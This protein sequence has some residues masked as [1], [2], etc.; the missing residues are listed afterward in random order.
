[1][2]MKLPLFA[3]GCAAM[4]ATILAS[5]AKHLAL[6]HGEGRGNM[7]LPSTCPS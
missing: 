5:R 2:M 7:T 3:L 6:I 1:M 4:G